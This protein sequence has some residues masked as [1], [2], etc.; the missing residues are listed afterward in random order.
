MLCR[1]V[2]CCCF[3]GVS[4]LPGLPSLVLQAL[5]EVV[6]GP[7]FNRL[8]AACLTQPGKE[9]AAVWTVHPVTQSQ[10]THRDRLS[11]LSCL[12]T[13]QHT[14]D[15]AAAKS[16]AMFCCGPHCLNCFHPA[17][18]LQ[19][20]AVASCM[21]SGAPLLLCCWRGRSTPAAWMH[22]QAA[23]AITAHRHPGSSSTSSR[24]FPCSPGSSSSSSSRVVALLLAPHSLSGQE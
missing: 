18:V 6:D 3:A 14:P 23:A 8:L 11:A 22:S 12:S 20:P 21:Q 24:R 10:E 13:T 15:N 16:T 19:A 7:C 2:L 9:G 5:S 17:C 4:W 1:A